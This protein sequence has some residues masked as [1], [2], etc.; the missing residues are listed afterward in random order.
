LS[1]LSRN[2]IIGSPF[3]ELISVDSTNNYAMRQVKEGLA[4]HGA[5]YFAFE[6]TA[7]KGQRNKQW[8][9]A[10][11]ENI[12][13]S[14]ILETDGLL[15]SRQ[16]V[17]SVVAALSA[18]DLF[19]NYTTYS[20]RIKWPNDIYFGD[21]KAGGIL[22][23]TIVTEGRCRFAVIGFGLNINQTAFDDSLKNPT[24]LKHVTQRNHNIRTL[25]EELCGRLQQRFQQFQ[26]GEEHLLLDE[27]NQY[28]YKRDLESKFKKDTRIFS[29][30][31]KRVDSFGRLTILNSMEETL[32]FGTVEWLIT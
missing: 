26:N 15:L 21:R 13:L 11:G 1:A 10:R 31:V 28:L 29:G 25:S 8:Q 12:I 23:E 3:V 18:V 27:Y 32:E 6:Q 16:F 17:L 20:A 2:N 14:V 22:I 7:G 19:N 4:T 5:A 9:S 30:I 24:S